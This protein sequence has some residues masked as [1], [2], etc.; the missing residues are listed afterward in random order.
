MYVIKVVPI[1]LIHISGSMALVR[2]RHGVETKV[3]KM[4][5]IGRNEKIL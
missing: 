1:V 3:A 4:D 5:T 2:S